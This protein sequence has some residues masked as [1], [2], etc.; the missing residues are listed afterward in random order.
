MEEGGSSLPVEGVI[1]LQNF[2]K[3]RKILFPPSLKPLF[4]KGN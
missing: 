1:I 3:F 2:T 4:F